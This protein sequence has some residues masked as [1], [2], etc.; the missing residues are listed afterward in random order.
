MAKLISQVVWWSAGCLLA[1]GIWGHLKAIWALVDVWQA[2]ETSH[3]KSSQ[4]NFQHQYLPELLVKVYSYP[5]VVKKCVLL[6]CAWKASFLKSGHI[7]KTKN[8]KYKRQRQRNQSPAVIVKKAASTIPRLLHL[9]WLLHTYNSEAQRIAK[10][11]LT[12]PIPS[13]HYRVTATLWLK[14]HSIS[15]HKTQPQNQACQ[16]QKHTAKQMWHANTDNPADIYTSS[17]LGWTQNIIGAIS[18]IWP[19]IGVNYS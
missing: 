10:E 16:P 17:Q 3:S 18:M 8:P 5:L 9:V 12:Q 13:Q 15:W 7:C 19:S 6:L 2:S 1:K 4:G 14:S 11:R